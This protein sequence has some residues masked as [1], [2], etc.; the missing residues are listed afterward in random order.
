MNLSNLRD[1]LNQ[2]GLPVMA[3]I[4]QQI[5][6]ALPDCPTCHGGEWQAN[7]YSSVTQQAEHCPDCTD[8]R[9]DLFRALAIARAVMT[10]DAYRD[11]GGE[12]T[13]WDNA[14][15]YLRTVTA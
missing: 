9:M 7:T 10:N 3:D 13:G 14:I 15:D 6:D 11:R 1:N 4:I 12:P 8:G 5:I 2:S